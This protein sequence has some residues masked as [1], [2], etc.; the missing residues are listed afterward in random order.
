M[1]EHKTLDGI[2]HF[3][4]ETGTEGGFFAV[5]DEKYIS[6]LGKV[7]EQWKY[8]G[9][10]LLKD[11]DYLRIFDYDRQTELWSGT[12]NLERFPPFTESI[13][14]MWMH[15]IQKDVNREE[16]ARYFFEAYPAQLEL[17]REV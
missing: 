2:L 11:S 3:Y 14:G 12:I 8:E 7:T 13:F 1:S 17:R 6:D 9:L 15:S 10:H 16:W 4:S 5:Q